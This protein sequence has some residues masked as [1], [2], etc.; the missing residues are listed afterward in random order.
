M[1]DNSRCETYQTS[2][3]KELRNQ[4]WNDNSRASETV[5]R[6]TY[7]PRNSVL[8]RFLPGTSAGQKLLRACRNGSRF[9]AGLPRHLLLIWRQPGWWCSNMGPINNKLFPA[10]M[11]PQVTLVEVRSGSE[12]ILWLQFNLA[13]LAFYWICLIESVK[14]L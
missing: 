6:S 9:I 5:R 7:G 10:R 8:S 2:A 13:W 3:I 12:S 4:F 1:S 14:W 11:I